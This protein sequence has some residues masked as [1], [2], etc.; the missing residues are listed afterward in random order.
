[1]EIYHWAWK[2]AFLKFIP[3]SVFRIFHP[4]IPALY[5]LSVHTPP[6]KRF[7]CPSIHF[8]RWSHGA[9]PPGLLPLNPDRKDPHPERRGDPESQGLLRKV[10]PGCI[11]KKSAADVPHPQWV[12]SGWEQLTPTPVNYLRSHGNVKLSLTLWKCKNV[13]LYSFTERSLPCVDL[14]RHQVC[15]STSYRT[16]HT[17]LIITALMGE[18]IHCLS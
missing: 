3:C 4:L 7:V 2:Y 18:I 14:H 1:M 6:I 10:S 8:H 17:A 9:G 5:H 11:Q 12:A 16:I 15:I 13:F